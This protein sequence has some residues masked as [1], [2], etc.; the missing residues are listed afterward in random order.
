MLQEAETGSLGRPYA[1]PRSTLVLDSEGAPTVIG[2]DAMG[3]D[4][5]S[6]GNRTP[7]FQDHNLA[8]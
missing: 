6:E 2:C 1:A 3:I 7:D 8:L 5:V 4:G